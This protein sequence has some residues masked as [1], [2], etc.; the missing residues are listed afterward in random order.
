MWYRKPPHR[1]QSIALSRP[2]IKE[3]TAQQTATARRALP[4]C[5]C[6]CAY[7]LVAVQ[8]VQSGF[9]RP[10]RHLPRKHQRRMPHWD[11]GCGPSLPR[12]KTA[13]LC[14]A[15]IPGAP[16][17]GAPSCARPARATATGTVGPCD[18]KPWQASRIGKILQSARPKETLACVYMYQFASHDAILQN[19]ILIVHDGY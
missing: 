4:N 6:A 9:T 1:T 16:L 12:H 13:L 18:A 14:T 8:S 7:A 3:F 11:R 17:P 19:A 10:Q 2:I 15:L 5:P